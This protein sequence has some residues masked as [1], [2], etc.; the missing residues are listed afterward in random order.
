MNMLST[1][2]VPSIMISEFSNPGCITCDG[3][4]ATA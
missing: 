4:Q 2:L 1:F 3:V